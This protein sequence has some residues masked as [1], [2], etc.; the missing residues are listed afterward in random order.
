M[1]PWEIKHN[2]RV[3]KGDLTVSLNG[4]NKLPAI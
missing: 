2:R 3:G 1:I 4:Y